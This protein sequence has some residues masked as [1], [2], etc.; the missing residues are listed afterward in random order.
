[1]APAFSG[2]PSQRPHRGHGAE[3]EETKGV[4]GQEPMAAISKVHRAI[5]RNE[6]PQSGGSVAVL[7]DRFDPQDRMANIASQIK[8]NRQNERRRARRKSQLS[9][10]KTAVSKGRE[11]TGEARGE[12]VRAAQKALDVATRQKLVHANTAA[13]RKSSLMR[14]MRQG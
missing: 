7:D 4:G 8:R 9:A 2:P 1:M 12:V 3:K 13:R 10:L 5:L 11:A 14:R 6:E